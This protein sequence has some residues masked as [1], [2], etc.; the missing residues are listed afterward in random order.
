MGSNKYLN[1]F[2]SKSCYE[3]ISEYIRI[4]KVSQNKI[5]RRKS[6]NG[7]TVWNGLTVRYGTDLRYRTE[8]EF[9]ADLWI[10]DFEWLEMILRCSNHFVGQTFSS[11]YSMCGAQCSVFCDTQHGHGQLARWFWFWKTKELFA[12]AERWAHC[13]LGVVRSAAAAENCLP[14]PDLRASSKD[15]LARPRLLMYYPT[16]PKIID[17]LFPIRRSWEPP[18]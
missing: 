7:L 15:V 16:N 5:G 8:T 1:I 12:S 3:R 13:N 9:W 10:F 14:S 17:S 11:V 18:G 2:V 4:Q 6:C